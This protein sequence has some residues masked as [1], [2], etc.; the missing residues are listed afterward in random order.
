MMS[1]DDINRDSLACGRCVRVVHRRMEESL[2]N[3]RHVV[4]HVTIKGSKPE[5]STTARGEVGQHG[6]ST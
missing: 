2:E 3:I 6:V 4:A 1:S 5:K